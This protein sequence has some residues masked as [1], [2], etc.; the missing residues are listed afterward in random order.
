MSNPKEEVLDIVRNLPEDAEW[1][2]IIEEIYFRMEVDEGLREADEG[3]TIP[4]E[5]VCERLLAL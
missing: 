1:R 4:L 2:D 3:K 5:E